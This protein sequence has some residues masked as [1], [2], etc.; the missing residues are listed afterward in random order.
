[1]NER[2]H[3]NPCQTAYPKPNEGR[4]VLACSIGRDMADKERPT[5]CESIYQPGLDLTACH[6]GVQTRESEI[7]AYLRDQLEDLGLIGAGILGAMVLTAAWRGL[8]RRNRN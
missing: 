1:M 7:N 3:P 2:I 8:G 5:T 4:L 6:L